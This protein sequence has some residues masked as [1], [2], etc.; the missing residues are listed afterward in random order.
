LHQCWALWVPSPYR[1]WLHCCR[2]PVASVLLHQCW[3]S[4]LWVSLPLLVALLPFPCCISVVA[5]VLGI[6]VVSTLSL[7]LLVAWLPFPC[8]VSVGDA[9]RIGRQTDRHVVYRQ[10]HRHADT[11]T[12]THTHTQTRHT[13]THTQTHTDTHKTQTQTHTRTHTHTDR[14]TDRQMYPWMDCTVWVRDNRQ[15]ERER[16]R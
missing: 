14:Q 13:Q 11:H 5:S 3:A 9:W 7:P 6:G 4:A 1:C 12:H 15:I 10:T 8:C 2:F 16:E